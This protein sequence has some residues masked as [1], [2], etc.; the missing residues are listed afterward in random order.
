MRL[1]RALLSGLS[2]AMLAAIAPSRMAVSDATSAELATRAQTIQLE[3]RL[4]FRGPGGETVIVAAG[5]HAVELA[6]EATLRLISSAGEPAVIAARAVKHDETLD[7]P[8]ALV[9]GDGED[10]TH[11][12]LLLPDG[13]GLDA[14][15]SGSSV[16]V[17]GDVLALAN[18]ARIQQALRSRK[19]TGPPDTA[20]PARALTRT[21]WSFWRQGTEAGHR[22][23]IDYF[24]RA[25]ALDPAHPPAHAGLA[26]AYALLYLHFAPTSD[27]LSKARAHVERALR[28]DGSLAEAHAAQGY[29]ESLDQR[30]PVAER[31]L[32]RALE[33]APDWATA[34]LWYGELL[35]K[36]GRLD[37]SLSAVQ[38]ALELA[39]YDAG[40]N[41]IAA[42]LYQVGRRYDRSIEHGR[43]ALRLNPALPQFVRF[44]VTYAHW[45]TD[46]SANAIQVL[47]DQPLPAEAATKLRQVATEGG[48]RALVGALLQMEAERSGTPCTQLASV[49][50]TLLAF[51]EQRDRAFACL[52]R[53]LVEGR[54]PAYLELDPILEPLRKDPRFGPLVERAGRPRS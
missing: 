25:L 32:R 53:S 7:G 37:A 46:D 3:R 13:T 15:G 1:H 12:L 49:G 36:R 24:D 5:S 44:S 42:R 54:P 40:V 48:L 22:R 18:S 50:G 21:G 6:S 51:L 27:H 20:S 26:A 16:T 28:L 14:R 10:A 19:L 8:V 43:R 34:H 39:P 23:A 41:G 2:V 29:M 30:L 33:L 52:E 35:M 4:H 38:R 47:L 17:R 31:S 9:L 11:V 45:A